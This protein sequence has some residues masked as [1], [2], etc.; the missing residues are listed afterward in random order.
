MSTT[1][2]SSTNLRTIG[3]VLLIVALIALVIGFIYLLVPA[4]SLPS[5][6]GRVHTVSGHRSKRAIASLVAGGLLV[7]GAVIALVRSRAYAH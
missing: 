5:F 3:V 6:M 2:L 1:G 7:V 4:H